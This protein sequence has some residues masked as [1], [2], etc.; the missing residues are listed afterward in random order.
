MRDIVSLRFRFLVSLLI[1]GRAIM[2]VKSCLPAYRS[3]NN[4]RHTVDNKIV[5]LEVVDC[6]IVDVDGVGVVQRVGRGLL[7]GQ[8]QHQLHSQ[9]QWNKFVDFFRLNC[10][11]FWSFVLKNVVFKS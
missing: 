9:Q 6:F 7:P 11:F 5:F 8:H 10:G 2:C 4:K 3:E 1:K